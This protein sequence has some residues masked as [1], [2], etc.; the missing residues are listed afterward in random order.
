MENK[1]TLNDEELNQVTGGVND[2]ED[3][4]AQP[5][6]CPYCGSSSCSKFR[7]T[8]YSIAVRESVGL[9]TCHTTSIVWGFGL[10]SGTVIPME[11]GERTGNP[12]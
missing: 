7:S 4:M 10:S 1:K 2:P 6:A 3:D 9:F 8:I 11:G 12:K 5:A